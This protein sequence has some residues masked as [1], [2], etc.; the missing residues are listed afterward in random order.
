MAQEP[1]VYIVDDDSFIRDLVARVFANVGIA[2]RTF[3]SAADL[4]AQ[5]DLQSQC[6]LLL[7]VKMPDMSGPELQIVLRERG[8][9]LPIIFLT[10]FSDVPV[11]VSA[12]RNGA[13]DFLIKPFDA[14][15]LIDRVRQAFA[16][17]DARDD[18]P[19]T[20]DLLR[21]LATLTPREREVF[22]LMVTGQS[23]KEIARTLDCSFRT[24]DIH[25][26]RVMTKMGAAGL[27][28][29]VRMNID[30]TERSGGSQA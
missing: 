9:D 8:L 23:S 4:L 26:G 11:A 28:Q 13:L 1:T 25:R 5:A 10:G 21:R 27:A 30:L 2:V 3:G 17:H 6:V 7:D 14:T 24:V 18:R 15:A 22:D 29:L 12:M 19:S 16:R 20:S